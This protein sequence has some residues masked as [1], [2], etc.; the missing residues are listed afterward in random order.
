METCSDEAEFLSFL[1]REPGLCV[2]DVY[3]DWCGPCKPVQTVFKKI[4]VELGQGVVRFA[5]VDCEKVQQ[6]ESFVGDC[7]PV[8]LL[9]GGGNN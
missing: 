1:G 4:K 8:F 2:V 7:E 6:L 5:T 3:Q 9:F